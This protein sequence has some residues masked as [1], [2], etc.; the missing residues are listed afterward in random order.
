M[1]LAVL[2]RFL[3]PDDSRR[4]EILGAT[5]AQLL[6][7]RLRGFKRE[8]MGGGFKRRRVGTVSPYFP[9]RRKVK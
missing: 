1:M 2:K 7:A 8:L 3:Q 5:M 6:E 9:R 4:F